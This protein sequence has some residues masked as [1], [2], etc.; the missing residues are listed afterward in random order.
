MAVS[1]PVTKYVISDELAM[2]RKVPSVEG[3]KFIV[4]EGMKLECV[5]IKM[6]Q[7]LDSVPDKSK[8]T[9]FI[10]AGSW[11][12]TASYNNWSSE[13]F[14]DLSVS[15][16]KA[17]RLPL[18][19]KAIEDFKGHLNKI[20]SLSKKNKCRVVIS[21]LIPIPDEQD[22]YAPNL[23]SHGFMVDLV[24]TLFVECTKLVHNFNGGESRTPFLAKYLIKGT[25]HKYH[26]GQY[27]IKT[28]SY[29]SD[30]L[31]S[32]EAQRKMIDW[33]I[34]ELRKL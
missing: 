19:Q 34:L 32:K 27:K 2:R 9:F 28:A 1:S 11:N 12:I 21:S 8:V 5:K 25:K 6:E 7:V 29:D 3:V 31:P 16:V 17:K 14:Q 13:D 23:G 20:K 4:E 33:L 10:I 26:T 18:L 24:S 22:C 30:S 15:S